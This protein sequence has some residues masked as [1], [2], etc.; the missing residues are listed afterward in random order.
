MVSKTSSLD[1]PEDAERSFLE[2]VIKAILVTLG[3][4]NGQ[5]HIDV[6]TV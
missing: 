2:I 4:A 6:L 3:K 5:K 1:S